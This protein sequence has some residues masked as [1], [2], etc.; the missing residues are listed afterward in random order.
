MPSDGSGLTGSGVRRGTSAGSGVGVAAG[1]ALSVGASV[2]GV[3]VAGD[4][5]A[6]ACVAGAWVAG[7]EAGVWVAG[8]RP[9]AVRAAE[10]TRALP[11]AA[12]EAITMPKAVAKAA[13]GRNTRVTTLCRRL[14]WAAATTNGTMR[15]AR[16][17]GATGA[18]LAPRAAMMPCREAASA[19]HEGQPARC[20]WR[21]AGSAPPSRRV[22]S[23]CSWMRVQM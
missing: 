22:S 14:V 2:A 16:P 15:A 12:R 6:G 8:V 20:A 13:T 7:W 21:G 9:P 18:G 4:E 23:S 3:G 11:A 5:V 1:T 17:A 10:T 19:A